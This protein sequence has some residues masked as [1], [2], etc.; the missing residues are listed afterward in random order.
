MNTYVLWHSAELFDTIHTNLNWSVAMATAECA[1]LCATCRGGGGKGKAGLVGK[2][3][4][5]ELPPPK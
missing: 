3:E 1:A 4:Q 2:R 5:L